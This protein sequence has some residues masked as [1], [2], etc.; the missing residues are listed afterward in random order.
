MI[1]LFE[2]WFLSKPGTDKKALAKKNNRYASDIVTGMFMAYVAGYEK[3]KLNEA[4]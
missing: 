3:A 4:E 2:E 1:E